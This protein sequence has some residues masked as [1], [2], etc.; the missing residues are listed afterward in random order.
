EGADDLVTRATDLAGGK[1][2]VARPVLGAGSPPKDDQPRGDAVGSEVAE[3]SRPALE[4][5][6]VGSVARRIGDGIVSRLE[7]EH[8][9]TAAPLDPLRDG[10]PP[11]LSAAEDP[12]DGDMGEAALAELSGD[13]MDELSADRIGAFVVSGRE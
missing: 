4:R 8:R 12:R 2:L 1:R 13:R 10:H 11:L 7:E 6:R 5:H 9:I 3:E